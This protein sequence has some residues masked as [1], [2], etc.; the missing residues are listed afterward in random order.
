MSKIRGEGKRS[1]VP[2]RRKKLLNKYSNQEKT[3]KRCTI[4]LVS[5]M[6]T[7]FTEAHYNGPSLSSS[8]TRDPYRGDK[9]DELPANRQTTE[10][11]DKERSRVERVQ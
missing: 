7:M 8:V 5:I 11:N 1:C 6:K 4:F 2:S 9:E 3:Y 10:A